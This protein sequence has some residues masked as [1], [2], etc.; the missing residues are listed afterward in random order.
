MRIRSLDPKW[1]KMDP[2]PGHEHFF[3]IYWFFRLCVIL[4]LLIFMLRLDEPFRNKDNSNDIFFLKSS[5]SFK[6]IKK[7]LQF[8]IWYVA[9]WIWIWI[10]KKLKCQFLSI[11]GLKGGPLPDMINSLV[12]WIIVGW[13]CTLERRSEEDDLY[14]ERRSVRSIFSVANS[15]FLH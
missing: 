4:L 10:S 13:D 3:K 8:L 11:I 9:S 12:I 5:L 14:N 1:K 2:D 6:S 7:F 15:G